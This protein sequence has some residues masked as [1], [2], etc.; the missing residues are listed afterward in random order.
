MSGVTIGELV[1]DIIE[2]CGEGARHAQVIYM[3]TTLEIE[4]IKAS[5]DKSTYDK[6]RA[7]AEEALEAFE[8]GGD[9]HE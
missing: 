8:S 6:I 5:R 2:F 3:T 7:T 1:E 4:R 9:N